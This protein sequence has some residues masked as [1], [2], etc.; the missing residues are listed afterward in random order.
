MPSAKMVAQKPVGN[1][2]PLSS[3]GQDALADGAAGGVPWADAGEP[4]AHPP[5]KNAIAIHNCP[6]RRERSM[7]QPPGAG[8]FTGVLRSCREKITLVLQHAFAEFQT[9]RIQYTTSTGALKT[10]PAPRSVKM[11]VG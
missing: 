10:Y 5:P 8:D 3:P 4:S 2:S 11:K 1:F 9:K 7:G 6:K